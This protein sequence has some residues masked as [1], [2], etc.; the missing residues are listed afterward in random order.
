VRREFG[1]VRHVDPIFTMCPDERNAECGVRSAECGGSL[2]PATIRFG[3][4]CRLTGQKGIAYLLEA[5]KL[6]HDRHGSVDFTFGGVGPKEEQ[7]RQF[8]ETNRL[9]GVRVV[10][11]NSAPE[12]VGKLDVFV[13]PSVDDAMPVAIAEALMCG[14]PCIVSNV[15]GIPDLVRDGVEGFV[16]ES[17]KPDLILDRMER[18]AAM[19]AAEREVFRRCARARYE[20]VCRPESVGAVVAG[21]YR[22]MLEKAGNPT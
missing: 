12:I 17:R 21:H 6:F 2:E 19:R 14:C 18:F 4:I 8:V 15:G 13:H 10:R 20:E 9:D 3:V 7:I 22:A 16:I 1:I 11:V 5:L